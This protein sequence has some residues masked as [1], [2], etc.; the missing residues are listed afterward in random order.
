M[1]IAIVI[2]MALR[3]WHTKHHCHYHSSGKGKIKA[4]AF[5]ALSLPLNKNSLGYWLSFAGQTMSS[6]LTFRGKWSGWLTLTNSRDYICE[7]F[8]WLCLLECILFSGHVRLTI[9]M[10]S[11]NEMCVVL[12]S[13][14]SKILPFSLYLT[15]AYFWIYISSLFSKKLCLVKTHNLAMEVIDLTRGLL[16]CEK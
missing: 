7:R 3:A 4:I 10:Y 2:V 16:L 13:K 6:W 5:L 1:P 15:L 14:F 8:C 9:N 12:S 11:V